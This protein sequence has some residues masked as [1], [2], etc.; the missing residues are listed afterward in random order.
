MLYCRITSGI[1]PCIVA[2]SAVHISSP[3]YV[4]YDDLAKTDNL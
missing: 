3:G 4:F 2:A 1:Y